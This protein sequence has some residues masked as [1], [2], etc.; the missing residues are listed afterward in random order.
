MNCIYANFEGLSEDW[1]NQPSYPREI[2]KKTYLLR[3]CHVLRNVTMD[4][5]T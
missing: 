2:K 4:V 3:F 5:I 1:P